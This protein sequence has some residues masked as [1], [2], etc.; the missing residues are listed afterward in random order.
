[1]PQG[2]VEDFCEAGAGSASRSGVDEHDQRGLCLIWVDEGL[3]ALKV[4]GWYP[5]KRDAFSTIASWKMDQ[6][7][8]QGSK[9]AKADSVGADVNANDI[10]V[11]HACPV[12]C[13]CTCLQPNA[14]RLRTGVIP[15]H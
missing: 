10:R 13:C 4:C 11:T 3:G 7:A 6:R 9:R 8:I 14:A 15:Q 12:T 5:E 2:L 1:M